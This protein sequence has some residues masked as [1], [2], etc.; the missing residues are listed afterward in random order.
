MKKFISQI[1]QW[2][3]DK[4][5]EIHL[6][7]S[8]TTIIAFILAF[9]VYSSAEKQTKTFMNQMLLLNSNSIA[10]LG[11]R[12]LWINSYDGGD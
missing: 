4:T 2:L 3:N 6:L 9:I 7:A 8:I 10:Q 11:D 12:C 5:K 1:W